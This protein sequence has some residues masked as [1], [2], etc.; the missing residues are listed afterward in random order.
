MFFITIFVESL[1]KV[2]IILKFFI[3]NNKNPVDAVEVVCLWFQTLGAG[4]ALC[5]AA[6]NLS[7]IGGHHHHRTRTR[8][9]ALRHQ[10]RTLAGGVATTSSGYDSFY[11][12][13]SPHRRCYMLR[14][15]PST[16]CNPVATQ[17]NS[18]KETV[19]TNGPDVIHEQAKNGNLVTGESVNRR[20]SEKLSDNER[21]YT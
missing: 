1:T 6:G 9:N 13:H 19:V 17:P 16:L 10:H 3:K 8:E 2:L 11:S 12:R 18:T 4:G 20:N 7:E 15:L 5:V 14:H 21:R